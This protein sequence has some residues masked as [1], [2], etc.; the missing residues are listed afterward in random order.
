MISEETPKVVAAPTDHGQLPLGPSVASLREREGISQAEL[1]RRAGLSP[2][3][4]SRVESGER[5]LSP[6]EL[7]GLVQ[8][9]DSEDARAFLEYYSQEWS[10]LPRPP[11]DH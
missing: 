8:A 10:E 11:F 6:E 3:V 7:V 5:T 2:A 1:A 9:L 4:L